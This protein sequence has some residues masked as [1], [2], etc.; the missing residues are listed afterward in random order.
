MKFLSF[1]ASLILLAATAQAQ[2]NQ[3]SYGDV[4]HLQNGWNNYGGGFL[5]TRGYQKDY[6]K[7]GNF[8]C[9]S[10][11]TDPKRDGGS[12]SW[13][14]MS[15]TGKAVGTPVLVND[16][17]YL[18]NQWSGNGGY[19]ETRGYEK[20]YGTTGNFLCV[21]TATVSN[22]DNGSGTWK[23]VSATGS[24]A[25]TAVSENA[26]IHLQNGWNKFGGGYLDTKGYQKDYAKTGN[27][28]CV[29][30]ATGPKRDG[31]SGTW[32]ISKVKTVQLNADRFKVNAFSINQG[33]GKGEYFFGVNTNDK[34]GRIVKTGDPN[35]TVLQ[36][37]K[38]DLGEN[39]YAF[40]AENYMP[41]DGAGK[42][43]YLVAKSEGNVIIEYLADVKA[44]KGAQFSSLPAFTKADGA[45]QFL[46]FESKLK[47]GF[48]LRHSGLVLYIHPLDP[49]E[50][51]KQDASWMIQKM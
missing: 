30:T 3:L 39:T 2:S 15:A 26:E 21:S 35:T 48:Y 9:V 37:K 28:L 22:R 19:L 24:P 50:L 25:G 20:D 33:K 31:K 32:K 27:W 16:D 44:D 47:P 8:L 11:A 43:A 38:V 40:M 45:E 13:K 6:A 23:I 29:S 49:S 1:L 10:T 51:Y 7:T 18:F 17:V 46:S 36:I 12:G 41:K 34:T 14:I 4:I 5:D 42:N